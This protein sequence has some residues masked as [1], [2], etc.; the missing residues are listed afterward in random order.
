MGMT[1]YETWDEA[2][3]AGFQLVIRA[4]RLKGPTE[5]MQLARL[6]AKAL[7]MG[8]DPDVLADLISVG[9]EANIERMI[10][11]HTH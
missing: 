11:R 2:F 1:K 5:D 10:K 4:N 6:A 9:G 7:L 8:R 3:R